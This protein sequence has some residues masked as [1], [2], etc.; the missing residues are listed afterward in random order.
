MST[1]AHEYDEALLKAAPEIDKKQRQEGYS[2]DLLQ[3]AKPSTPGP[4]ATSPSTSNRDLERGVP[5]RS[6]T[7]SSAPHTPGPPAAPTYLKPT[8]SQ[9]FYKTKKGLIIIGAVLIAV[10]IAAVVGGV[11]G[12][13]KKNDPQNPV[14]QGL[15][16]PTP[17]P[18]QTQASGGDGQQVGGGGGTGEQGTAGPGEGGQGAPDGRP[19]TQSTVQG[20]PAPTATAVNPEVQPN[21]APP[22][23]RRLVRRRIGATG[24]LD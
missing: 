5:A 17:S 9:P 19:T 6:G 13:K 20:N 3:N 16:T 4:R 15:A 18:T 12:S 14:D 21:S 24:N 8:K 22:R 10:I 1:G 2:T 7:G 11:V 23:R